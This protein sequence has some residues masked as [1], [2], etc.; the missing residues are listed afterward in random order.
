MKMFLKYLTRILAVNKGYS[1]ERK[2]LF[3]KGMGLGGLFIVLN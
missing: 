2:Q 1:Q 3:F